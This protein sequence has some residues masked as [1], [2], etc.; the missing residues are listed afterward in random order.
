[1]SPQP[2]YRACHL[3]VIFL[4]AFCSFRTGLGSEHP[5]SHIQKV[6]DII[7]YKDEI[8]YSSFP[9]IV[10]RPGGE[11]LVAF[12]RAPDRRL[13]GE[14]R[15]THTDPNSYIML[16]RSR[17]DGSTWSPAELVYAHPLGGSQD[18]CMIQLSDH[19]ILCS[20]YGW[21]LTPAYTSKDAVRLGNFS[22]LGGYLLRSKDGLTWQAP[23]APPPM[24]GSTSRDILGN[25]IPAYN[26]GAM[27]QGKDGR[28]Y[29]AVVAYNGSGSKTGT[30]LLIS[31]NLGQS[32]ESSCPIA[33]DEKVTFNETSLYE[34]PKGALVA[35]MRTEGFD[36]HT[37]TARSV[38]QGKS[39]Q[40]WEDTGFQGH[41]HFALRLPDKRVLLVYGYRHP[42]FGVRARVLEAEC[43]DVGASPEIIL[44]DDGGNGDLGYPWATMLSRSQILVVYYFNIA[45]GTRYIA[46]TVLSLN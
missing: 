8:F 9:S 29:W 13:F 38:D 26:R 10:R 19:S 18:P 20:S 11:L 6:K 5:A 39:F 28:L 21:A 32:W 35:F 16:V 24:P 31:S 2:S 12:R 30:H 40:H 14:P 4:L 7:V 46:G 45:D 22:F 33:T 25:V 41:P 3:C 37:A 27:C 44:R 43:G 34:T 23:I 1:M 15:T 17:D 42:A 36:D